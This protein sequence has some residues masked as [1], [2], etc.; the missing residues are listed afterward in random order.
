MEEGKSNKAEKAKAKM[1]LPCAAVMEYRNGVEFGLGLD[2]M[3]FFGH[4][5]LHPHEA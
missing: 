5:M 4:V 2:C 3:R 1:G